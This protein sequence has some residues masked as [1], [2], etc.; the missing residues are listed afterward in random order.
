MALYD[1]MGK[2]LEVPVY[3]LMGQKVRD[4]CSVAAWTRPCPPEVFRDEI[5]RAASQGYI[6]FKMHSNPL[7]DVIEQTR[8]AA[9]VAPEGFKLHWDFNHNRSLAAVLPIGNELEENHPIVGYI[10]DPLQRTDIDGWRTLR[11]KTRIPI[12]MHVPQLDGIQEIIY[13]AA[14]NLHDRRRYRNDTHAGIRVRQS[15]HSNDYTAE[16]RHAHEGVDHAHGRRSPDRNR[17]LD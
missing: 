15:E 6:I 1:V 14:D 9:E 5:R 12:I 7:Y 3:K 17:A 16:R 13:G 4:A 2:Y 10:E 8:L 11:Q